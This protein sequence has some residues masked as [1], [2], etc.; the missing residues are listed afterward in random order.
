MALREG[1]RPRK[2]IVDAR[3]E[4]IAPPTE[5]M[6]EAM[7]S[8]DYGW[9]LLGEDVN[10][11]QLEEMGAEMT[12]KEAALLVP[13]TSVA[14]L[15]G[16]M[17][18]AQRG[19]VAIMEARC[20]LWWVEERNIA[21]HTGA[22]PRL[23]R[24][25][26]FGEMSL[27]DIE[28]TI[29]ESGY[30]YRPRTSLICLENT[31]NICGGTALSPRYM[32]QVA[33]LAHKHGAVVLVDGARLF[34][35]AIAHNVPLSDLAGPVDVV[36]ISLNKGIGAPY[37][38]MVCGTKDFIEQAG[39]NQRVLGCHSVHKE[40]IFAAAAIVGLKTMIDRLIEDHIMARR[41]AELIASLPG[42]EVDMETVQT[43]IVRIETMSIDPFILVQRVF[44]R[45][46]G[47][48]VLDQK[49]VK[50]VTHRKIS[51]KDIEFAVKVIEEALALN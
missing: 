22:V 6:W 16:M 38:A 34:N 8:A 31:H 11:N 4:F 43:N 27:E 5:A 40:G 13:T 10:V 25:N 21:H 14:N 18:Y 50:M 35:A 46:V 20:H 39:K 23:I 1:K 3:G 42:L 17:G 48:S 49:A 41:L 19:D 33:E 44:D 26:K 36:S 32:T 37:G 47:M 24:G 51:D 9:P 15:L 28:G 45:G 29:M 12:G 30:S 7:K 2:L